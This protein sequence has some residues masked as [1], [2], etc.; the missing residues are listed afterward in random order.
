MAIICLLS[1]IELKGSIDFM[2]ISLVA[3]F[4]L[5]ACGE[6]NEA[7][8][9]TSLNRGPAYLDLVSELMLGVDEAM[10]RSESRDMPLETSVEG[11]ACVMSNG[12]CDN[13]TLSL[14]YNKCVSSVTNQT[15]EG[16]SVLFYN[17]RTTCL[18]QNQD[19]T[20]VRKPSYQRV[21]SGNSR[22]MIS[23]TNP[24]V[25]G[26]HLKKT[27]S[28]S[29]SLYV[30]NL[31]RR[32]YNADG[33]LEE[34]HVLQVSEGNSMQIM[35]TTRA[36]RMMTGGLL[37]VMDS[38]AN[39]EVELIANALLWDNTCNCPISGHW[40]GSLLDPENLDPN[41]REYSLK[42]D[43]KSCGVANVVK[44]NSATLLAETSAVKLSGCSAL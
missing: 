13:G 24:A 18:I 33:S 37:N 8:L 6:L 16:T 27:G 32:F 26:F 41:E 36:G 34:R 1:K 38:L 21:V 43:M 9:K 35:G 31:Q 39:V 23:V 29:F 30:K 44:T 2:K 15:W 11:G 19:E 4:F 5:T 28:N 10:F 3:A 25:D 42:I 7:S 14:S 22:V 17:G 40:L 20:L 12:L